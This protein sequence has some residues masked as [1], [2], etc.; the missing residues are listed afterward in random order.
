MGT[1]MQDLRFAAR[2]LVKNPGFTAVAVLTLTVGIGAN[3]AIF[4][5]VN[6]MLF[7]PVGL[8]EPDRLVMIYETNRKQG[9]RRE[10]TIALSDEWRRH[11]RLFEDIARGGL[12][13]E[14][15]RDAPYPCFSPGQRR[16]FTPGRDEYR[17]NRSD[18]T[19]GDVSSSGR[20]DAK[21]GGKVRFGNGFFFEWHRLWFL[22]TGRGEDLRESFGRR[23]LRHWLRLWRERTWRRT[24]VGNSGRGTR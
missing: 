15:S 2:M 16:Q 14:N 19:S 11:S 10:P 20:L 18:N 1:L 8:P 5:I 13:A 3:T 24:D 23:R 7:R 9:G 12:G 6:A 17:W 22:S 4:S 21:H